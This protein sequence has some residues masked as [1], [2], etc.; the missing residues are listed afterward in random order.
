MSIEA[1]YDSTCP[2]CQE[3]ITIGD[4]IVRDTTTDLYVH[5]DCG[6]PETPAT[7]LKR[8]SSETEKCPMCAMP[9]EWPVHG[10]CHAQAAFSGLNGEP[11]A[12]AVVTYRTVSLAGVKL[13]GQGDA[14]VVDDDNI[15][16]AWVPEGSTTVRTIE[17]RPEPKRDRWKRYILP[18][19]DNPKKEQ[20]YTRATTI[21]DE[22]KDDYLI[23]KWRERKL[24]RGMGMKEELYGLAASHTDPDKEHREI[25]EN[26]VERAH[27]AAGTNAKRDKGMALHRLLEMLD[28]GQITLA[29]I[30]SIWRGQA[31]SYQET[32]AANGITVEPEHI[33]Q[34]YVDDRYQ[35]AGM[36]DRTLRLPDRRLRVIGDLK[37]LRVSTP[38]PTPTGWSTMGE[39]EVGDLVLDRHGNPTPVTRKSEV[40][41]KRCYR[42]IFD[43]RTSL[44]CDHDHR[45]W[46]KPARARSEVV[47][48][49]E[50]LL[51][52]LRDPVTGQRH[53]QI[54][55]PVAL[56][57][58]EADLPIDPYVLGAWLGDGHVRGGVISKPLP[59]LWTEIKRRG[60]QVSIWPS[61]MRSGTGTVSGLTS[62]LRLTGLLYD[63]HIPLAYLRA[64]ERQRRELLAG[65]MDT[66][67]SFNSAR[68]ECVYYSTS[69]RLAHDVEELLYTLGYRVTFWAGQ[70]NGFGLKVECYDVKFRPHDVSPFIAKADHWPNVVKPQALTRRL[71]TDVAEIP[72]VATQCISVASSDESYLAGYQ[73]VPTHNTGDTVK[74][75]AV[76]HACQLAIYQDHTDTFDVTTKR[77]VGK[78]DIDPEIGII[79]HL[80]QGGTTCELIQMDL[81]VGREA[82]MVALERRAIRKMDDRLVRKPYVPKNVIQPYEWISQRLWALVGI[83]PAVA[84]VL[85]THW[86]DGVRQPFPVD[87]TREEVDAMDA[88]LQ[89]LE[90]HLGAPFA[91]PVAT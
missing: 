48:T 15:V 62:K 8:P 1:Q 45:W 61:G 6:Q 79:I 34:V 82:Y 68:Q 7:L 75:S 78:L 39:L 91:L 37:G 42:V 16:A 24:A 46:V 22:I 43:D 66:D 5:E 59:A 25:F 19:P 71:V 36:G 27:E 31:R 72:T 20:S 80:P 40:H 23:K 32:L 49:T 90:R 18:L 21:C 73:M 86:P 29:E 9:T 50:E 55:N 63:K 10:N 70:R 76:E 69:K 14:V 33:E 77:R 2:A 58:S 81:A 84:E 74:Y 35:V 87:P 53:L 54:V 89:P 83:E 3:S 4:P 65:L 85:A 51:A 57:L 26:I 44:E 17:A 60:H 38:I 30:P 56:H 41:W 47:M 28:L 88:T 64:S 67:G 13:L 11:E 12:P 52:N